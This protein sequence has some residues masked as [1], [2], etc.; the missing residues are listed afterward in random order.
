L[1]DAASLF[2]IRAVPARSLPLERFLF[3]A[4]MVAG[5]GYKGWL[6]LID[7][8]ELISQYSFLQRAR[9][10]AELARWMGELETQR[11][12]GIL[13]VATI[14]EDFD[15]KVLEGKADL[16]DLRSKLDARGGEEYRDLAARAEAG[17]RV[18]RRSA[19]TL[20]PPNS[21][22]LDD[23]YHHLKSLHATA[24]GW[25]PP[26][27]ATARPSM[28]TRMRAHVRRWI[29]EWDLTRL[30]P[31]VPVSIEE[32]EL[33]PNYVEDVDLESPPDVSNEDHTG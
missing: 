9:S 23:T 19:V 30:Y 20:D 3:T 26:D 22:A 17:M 4:R 12:P 25:E 6:L 10:Y 8:V 31:D 16:S 24:Y 11:C 29:N 33:T 18:I 7:E 28:M 13:T 32:R 1:L 21:E 27:I 15:P 2:R 14:T 5:A